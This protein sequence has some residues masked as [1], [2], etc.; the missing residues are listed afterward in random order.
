MPARAWVMNGSR[1]GERCDEGCR[2]PKCNVEGDAACDEATR[3]ANLVSVHG[4]EAMGPDEGVVNDGL[5]G[6]VCQ[7]W[8][9]GDTT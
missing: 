1:G 4:R 9:G 2:G 3:G 8:I 6:W 7:V 5:R